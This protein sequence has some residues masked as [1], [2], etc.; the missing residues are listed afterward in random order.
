HE[1]ILAVG[2]AHS[3]HGDAELDTRHGME[4]GGIGWRQI[5]RH[6]YVSLPWQCL[7]F[8]PEPHG[9]GSLRPTFCV[10][11]TIGCAFFFVAASASATSPLPSTNAG[12]SYSACCRRTF[13]TCWRSSTSGSASCVRIST[14]VSFLMTSSL[15]DST[16]APKS[17]N[18]SRLYSCFGFFCA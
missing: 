5:D 6:R 10:W 7:Y 12:S 3:R 18:A 9:Q 11:R 16:M 8:L 13:S 14:A 2:L 15:T 1:E 4:G 17:S